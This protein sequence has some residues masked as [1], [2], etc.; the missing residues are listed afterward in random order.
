MVRIIE[1]DFGDETTWCLTNFPKIILFSLQRMPI[2]SVMG[3]G[4]AKVVS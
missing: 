2:A 4:M 1:A 3:I